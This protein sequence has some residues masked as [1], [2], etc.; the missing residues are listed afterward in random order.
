MIGLRVLLK[1]TGIFRQLSQINY[2]K[3]EI[4]FSNSF[5]FYPNAQ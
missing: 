1:N 4:D 3:I 2:Y 5:K